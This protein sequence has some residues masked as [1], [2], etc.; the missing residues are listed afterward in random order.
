MSQNVKLLVQQN[1]KNQLNKISK[2]AGV[3]NRDYC[4]TRISPYSPSSSPS[5]ILPVQLFALAVN[6]L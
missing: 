5:P 4:A 3:N 6:V 2:M 1:R